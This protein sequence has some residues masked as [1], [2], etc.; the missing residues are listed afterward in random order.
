MS[1]MKY[2]QE[3]NFPKRIQYSHFIPNLSKGNSLKK[4]RQE[5][6][7]THIFPIEAWTDLYASHS[8]VNSHDYLINISFEKNIQ[9]T[10]HLNVNLEKKRWKKLLEYRKHRRGKQIPDRNVRI[11]FPMDKSNCS[12]DHHYRWIFTLYIRIW[13]YSQQRKAYSIILEVD[14]V[15]QTWKNQQMVSPYVR[16]MFHFYLMING[17]TFC[18]SSLIYNWETLP[19]FTN[20]TQ[21]NSSY[22]F[23]TSFIFSKQNLQSFQRCSIRMEKSFCNMFYRKLTISVANLNE[24]E[25]IEGLICFNAPK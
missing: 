18:P 10:L 7:N 23:H 16:S 20:L 1:W 19:Y 3:V 17:T 25:Y 24:L 8:N 11:N 14:E 22:L 2:Q 6:K 15:S 13:W 4:Y 12:L 21:T 9:W 5:K